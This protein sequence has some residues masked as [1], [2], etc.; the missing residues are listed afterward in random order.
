MFVSVHGQNSINF[1]PVLSSPRTLRYHLLNPLY[2]LNLLNWMGNYK[3]GG[4]TWREKKN[5]VKAAVH[6]FPGPDVPHAH[7]YGIY[8]LKRNEG[9][10]NVGQ[11]HG[12]A[13][14]AVFNQ[15]VAAQGREGGISGGA[16]D[17]DNGGQR[18]VQR[19]TPASME[20]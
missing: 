5:P 14:F 19:D 6:D 4:K 15:G 13:Q 9:F 1:F 17:T 7:P 2:S 3:N 8:D 12:T 11:D 18:R 16:A 20:I 10:V